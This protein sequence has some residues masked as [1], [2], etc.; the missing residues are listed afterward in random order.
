MCNG[1]A[2]ETKANTITAQVQDDE[3]NLASD[4]DP[5]EIE[6]IPPVPADISGQVR[7]DTDF[8]GDLSDLDNGISGVEIQLIDGECVIGF[9]CPRTN[10]NLA[11]YYNF[12]GILPGDYLVLETDPNG[13]VSTADS[14]GANDNQISLTVISGIDLGGNDF[15]DT[16]QTASILGQ[17][18]E[19][20]DGDGNIGDN[21]SGIAGVS[22]ELLQGYCDLGIDCLTTLTDSNGYYGFHNLISGEYIIVEN[23]LPDFISTNDSDPPN[24]NR[25]RATIIQGVNS[26]ANDFL[27]KIDPSTCIPPDPVS[28]FVSSTDPAAGDVISLTRSTIDVVFNQPMA[29]SGSGSVLDKSSYDNRIRN[30][31]AGR[32]VDI[33]SVSYYA[34]TRTATLV[35]DTSDSD[36]SPGSE[37]RLT[38][39]D[40]WDSVENVCGAEQ[41]ND[42]R[43]TFFTQSGI[44]GQIRHDQDGDGNLADNDPGIHGVTLELVQ[45]G[46]SL[47]SCPTTTSNSN[48][49][50]EFTDLPAGNYTLHEY[51]LS[52]YT[53]TADADGGNDNQINVTV[54][55]HDFHTR[56]DFL[57]KIDPSTCSPPDP[58]N[59]FVSST[60]PAA[61]DVISLT[62]TTIKV[63]FNQPMATSGSGSVLDLSSYDSRIR[64]ITADRNVDILSVS[65][66]APTR[67]ATLVLDTSDSDWKPGSEYRL[68]IKDGPGSITNPCGMHQDD[69]VFINFFTRSGISGQI[70][71]DVDVDGD[72]S[73]N[74]QGIHGVT[75]ELV[76]A[77]CSLG[78]CPTTTS[79]SNGNFRFTDLGAGTYRLYEYDLSGFTSTADTGGANDNQINLTVGEHDFLTGNTFLDTGSCSAPDPLS[80]FVSNITPANNSTLVSMATNSIT[81]Q[82][83]QPMDS[84]DGEGVLRLENYHNSL[85]NLDSGGSVAFT[86]VTYNSLSYT[87]TLSLD[88]A[89]DDWRP[90]TNYELT[91][92]NNI[93][94]ACGV[95]QDVNIISV[96]QTTSAIS[97]QVREDTDGD[98]NLNDEDPGLANVRLELR[99]GSC[100]IGADCRTTLT[101]GSGFYIFT[102]V[103][104]GNY[105]L[106]EYNLPGFTSTA[107][108]AG[109]NNDIIGINLTPGPISS[110]NDFLDTD[111]P[112]IQVYISPDPGSI[113]EGSRDI[114]YS[115]TV[116]NVSAE[117]AALINLSD[118]VF[119][120]LNGQGSC[121]VGGSIPSGGSYSCSFAGTI[122]GNAGDSHTNTLSSSVQDNSGNGA[123]DTDSSTVGF[124]DVEPSLSI[125]ISPDITEVDASGQAVLFTVQVNNTSPE[126]V[127]LRM[128]NDNIYGNLEGQGTCALSQTI[129]VGGSYSCT[130]PGEV[131][132]LIGDIKINE[133]TAEIQD[134]EGNNTSESSSSSVNVV[135]ILPTFTVSKIPSA[136]TIDPPLEV[137]FDI[138]VTNT[139][140]EPVTLESLVDDLYGDL[141]GLGSCDLSL[142]PL[143]PAFGGIYNCSFTEIIT[144][145]DG[146]IHTNIVTAQISDDEGNL[147]TEIASATVNI[148]DSLPSINVTIVPELPSLP[149]P[150]G[151]ISYT[152]TIENTSVEAITILSLLDD[153][154]G[155][156][157]GECSVGG[158]IL[159]GEIYQCSFMRLISGVQGDLVTNTLTASIEDDEGNLISGLASATVTILEGLPAP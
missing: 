13:Y 143:L 17:V 69:D 122:T 99:D 7:N 53:S 91:I 146:E 104:P 121:T 140:P 75:L 79:D 24:D 85:K 34:P 11:G 105:T 77:G 81:I 68:T 59:G 98:G 117:A 155:D 138:L 82:F 3:D 88:S 115:V 106:Y 159:A 54:G 127:E 130:Y 43:I 80:G 32:N 48:G 90:G 107:D 134:D 51:D 89:D 135:D 72:F 10:T 20:S 131:A 94:N 5:V 71:N 37:Y 83:N 15:L 120:D 126:S 38:I 49:Y 6:I 65:Y 61:G 149:E 109:A 64:N 96:F 8:D 87:A 141:N 78:S 42:V 145:S 97:G 100:T 150:G 31:T 112:L 9:N 21:D 4:S 58:V 40:G 56:R 33:L 132:G 12:S 70:R 95:K 158:S 111:K 102:N 18:R 55:D 66:H 67:T 156:L 147:V 108:S 62:T 39:L 157:S 151:E 84:E 44:S 113:G 116:E 60:D 110:Q 129:P 23:D 93:A 30:I 136:S 35:L 154:Y 139:S 57:D 142:R 46:C 22:I 25:I 29:T 128:L 19:D 26:V 63:V 45:A 36:W 137:S 124:T 86:G 133:I 47:G 153:L 2:G 144:G 101:S 125:L 119:G 27:D 52:N 16:D 152:I 118:N 1:S 76:Q 50:F 103:I 14:Q 114:N 92:S 73:D 148:I 123:S 74:D 28:G 41:D